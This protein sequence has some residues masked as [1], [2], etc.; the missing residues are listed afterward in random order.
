MTLI[1]QTHK[2][3]KIQRNNM[4]VS[5]RAFPY[6]PNSRAEVASK[7]QNTNSGLCSS[8]SL[9]SKTHL[10]QPTDEERGSLAK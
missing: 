5:S 10:S 2:D 6:I 3:L 8:C 7:P 1:W 9:I 4:L